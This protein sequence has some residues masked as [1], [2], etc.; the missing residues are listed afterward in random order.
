MKYI[1]NFVA[2]SDMSRY[3]KDVT[4]HHSTLDSI[5]C[6]CAYCRQLKR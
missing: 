6:S 5:Y 1:S 3:D 2:L 4:L